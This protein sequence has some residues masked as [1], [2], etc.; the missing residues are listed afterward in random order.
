VALHDQILRDILAGRVPRRF[1]IA[2]LKKIPGSKP[3]YYRVGN[4]EY[5]ENAINTI[6]RNHSTRPD[7]T[8][9]GDYVRKGRKPAFLW[10]GAGEYELVLDHQ[11]CLED[12]GSDNEEFEAI[13]GDRE[14]LI[15][16]GGE[17]AIKVPLPIKVDNALVLRIAEKHPD[18]ATIIVR[19]IAEMPFQEY[20]RRMPFGPAKH[21]WGERLAAYHWR[22]DWQTTCAELNGYS[23]RIRRAITTLKERGDDRLAREELL[24]SFKDVCVWGGVKLPE[25]DGCAL[26]MEVINAWESLAKGQEPPSHCHLNSAWTKLYALALPDSCVIYDSRVATAL[27]SILAPARSCAFQGAKWQPYRNLGTVPGRGG[28]RPR[29][30]GRHWPNGYRVWASQMAA[31]LLCRDVLEE[32]NRQ[33]PAR[34]DCRK[35]DD[36]SPWTLREVEAVLFMEGY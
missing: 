36:L 27:T 6:P 3:R 33:A 10:Y 21:G 28:S 11:H 24:D 17:T 19:Y 7:G 31:N 18:P 30:L 14:E 32:L 15:R 16:P 20:R 4:G 34:L 22:N 29:D 2:D 23:S 1:K 35:L 26:A 9:P 25:S 12:P 5:A 13:E 8:N